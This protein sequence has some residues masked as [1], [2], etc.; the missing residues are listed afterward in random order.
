VA[1]KRAF[2]LLLLLSA[3][4]CGGS[5]TSAPAP[6]TPSPIQVGVAGDALP[7]LAPGQSLQLWAV[8]SQ[9]DGTTIDVT[10]L[11]DWQSSSQA[12]A[13]VA[14][15]GLV[16]GVAEGAA[17]LTA[18]YRTGAGQIRAE[19]RMPGCEASTL[20]PV[21]RVFGPFGKP[22]C[23]S[24]NDLYGERI[25][26]TTPVS[27]CR[28][29]VRTDV[30]WLAL[31]PCN[32]DLPY[33][34]TRQ[35]FYLV[36]PNN[37]P[38]ARVGHVIVSF[39]K[40]AEIVHTVTQEPPFSCSYV[41]VPENVDFPKG[42]GTGSFEVVTTPRD[43]RWTASVASGGGFLSISRGSSGTGAGRVS[44]IV[45]A[46]TSDRARALDIV[47]RGLSGANPPAHHIIRLAGR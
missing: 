45:T 12:V 40:G 37:Y 13:T 43:C 15:G 35:F 33:N 19:V 20:S 42:G 27:D 26:V 38:D 21:S 7:A 36:Q 47:V 41:I 30:P 34:G 6:V 24:T 22:A 4:Q 32:Y 29:T 31:S 39:E 8:V 2:T 3:I 18:R 11:A 16:T 10:N 23:Q 1:A 14:P 9:S 5:T 44:Y 25:V 28:W 46:N 17:T